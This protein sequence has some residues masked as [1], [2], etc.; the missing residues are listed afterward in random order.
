MSDTKNIIIY[1]HLKFSLN[2][3]GIVVQYYLAQ[4][5]DRLGINV[6]IYNVHDNNAKNIIFNKFVNDIN[7]IDFNN[8]IVIYCEG[9][10]N[11]PLDAKYVV[12]WMLSKLGQNVPHLNYNSWGENELVYF[13]NNEIDMV[14][15]NIPRKM[16]SLFYIHP[17]IKAHNFKR[18]G[19]CYTI[20]KGMNQNHFKLGR[21]KELPRFEI[22]REHNQQQYVTIF[23]NFEYFISYDALTFLNIIAALCGCISII[24]PV[25][26]VS[27]QEYFKM[28]AF[29]DYMVDK[30][31]TEIYG[32]AYGF[33]DEE[34]NYSKSTLHLV[35]DQ[36][37][38]IHNWLIENSVK[39]FI[40]DM[41]HWELNKNKI[42]D[43]KDT[44]LV[45]DLFF[46]RN[47]YDDLQW[48]TNKQLFEHYHNHG[49][50][51]GRIANKDEFDKMYPEFDVNVYKFCNTDITWMNEYQLIHHYHHHGKFEDRI[52][53]DKNFCPDFDIEYYKSFNDELKN[54]KNS[55]MYISYFNL[56]NKIKNIKN[57]KLDEIKILQHSNPIINDITLKIKTNLSKIHHWDKVSQPLYNNLYLSWFNECIN[58]RKIS[59]ISPINNK[60]IY[61]D[62]YFV[63]N[64]LDNENTKYSVC[65]YYFENEEIILGLGLGTGNH[66]QEAHILYIYCI[67]E[68]NILYEWI[69]Y[70]FEDFKNKLLVKILFIFNNVIKKHNFEMINSKITTIYGYMNNMAHQLFNDYTGLYLMD[71]SK[72]HNLYFY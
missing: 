22:T 6:K 64:N 43:Y 66:P 45:V 3:G 49:I 24:Y 35:K 60:I 1:P 70:S 39:K 50:K 69:N 68:N 48:M 27:K 44:M 54:M 2:D 55:E 46:Y 11:N 13:F 38:D 32:L 65:N 62:K 20:R 56:I 30:N 28:T 33:S 61:T 59:I 34:I 47:I 57:T 21:F 67:K 18:N 4:V 58:N 41:N 29:Y 10:L 14:N 9:I 19:L 25:E 26:G 63:T 42:I 23:N 8:T 15:N 12:R 51:E 71:Y 36:M 5:L 52:I 53:C 40:E 7:T 16:L 37:T 17:N 72:V 31:I